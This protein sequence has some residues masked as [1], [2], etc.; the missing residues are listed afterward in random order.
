MSNRSSA[1]KV[2]PPPHGFSHGAWGSSNVTECPRLARRIAAQL[3]PGP[4]PTT[5]I[6]IRCFLPRAAYLTR[7]DMLEFSTVPKTKISVV[8]YLNSVP[9]AWGILAGPPVGHSLS[10]SCIPRPNVP[11]SCSRARSIWADSLHRISADPGHENRSGTRDCLP[12]SRSQRASHQSDALVEGQDRSCR[13]QFPHLRGSGEDRLR[14]NSST[15]VPISGLRA[16]D[17]AGMLAQNDAAVLIGDAA[18]KFIE[19]H[20]H[21]NAEKQKAFLKYGPEPLEVFDLAERWKFLTGLTFVF[22]F[23]A[24]RAGVP[25][26]GIVRSLEGVPRVWSSEHSRDRQALFRGAFSEGRVSARIPDR[27]RPL[28]H[29]RGLRGGPAAV[30]TKWPPSRSN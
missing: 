2:T 10:R 18:L 8:K 13:H 27:E 26:E 6:S 20:E 5:A 14:A 25:D 16:P 22:A 11:I 3:P 24:A 15:R 12:S 28:L 9:L 23:W 17:L 4:P 7:R 1:R 30:L 19:Q 21:P 29:G